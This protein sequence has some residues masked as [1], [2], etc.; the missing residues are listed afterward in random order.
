M[1]LLLLAT[2]LSSALPTDTVGSRAALPLVETKILASRKRGAVAQ[3]MEKGCANKAVCGVFYPTT[4]AYNMDSAATTQAQP[5]AMAP[6]DTVL[7]MREGAKGRRAVTNTPD[8]EGF[9][10]HNVV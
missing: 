5:L 6:H 4:P 9:S 3:H 1:N 10:N 2:G 8:F 7:S